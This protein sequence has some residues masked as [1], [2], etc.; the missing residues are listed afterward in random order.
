MK[1]NNKDL[2]VSSK[3]DSSFKNEDVS[4]LNS[5]VGL[6]EDVIRNI[7]KFKNEPEWMLEYRLKAYHA[8]L[9]MDM[10]NF[11][12]DLNNID[13]NSFTYF[14]R[15]TKKEESNWDDVP[16]TIKNTFK[17][18]GIP[19]AETVIMALSPSVFIVAISAVLII[20]PL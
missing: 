5:G 20:L 1:T 3:I 17:K 8:F 4:I 19:E 7:S 15:P 9:K 16:D 6:N 18:L 2:F 13:F 12:P 10:P 14:I 11:G